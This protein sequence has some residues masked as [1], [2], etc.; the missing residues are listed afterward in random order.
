MTF[1]FGYNNLISMLHVGLLMNKVLIL[2]DQRHANSWVSITIM[3]FVVFP[4]MYGTKI[5]IVSCH[6]ITIFWEILIWITHGALSIFPM[7][8]WMW[9]FFLIC[10]CNFLCVCLPSLIFDNLMSHCKKLKP[11]WV[12]PFFILMTKCPFHQLK[13][14]LENNY[15]L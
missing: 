3:T 4:I 8:V 9:I 15:L 6:S 11:C 13:Q 5:C 1:S 10:L 12:M 2:Y 7:E 14:Q